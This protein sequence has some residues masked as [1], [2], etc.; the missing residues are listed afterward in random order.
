MVD[1]AKI[2]HKIKAKIA[3]AIDVD[4]IKGELTPEREEELIDKIAIEITKRELEVPA[5]LFFSGLRPVS[6]LAAN[7]G[8][9]PVAPYLETLGLSNPYEYVSLFKNRDNVRR[10]LDKIEYFTLERRKKG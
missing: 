7:I 4:Y 1:F 3:G 9:L 2:L 10:I 8:I 5:I 6:G